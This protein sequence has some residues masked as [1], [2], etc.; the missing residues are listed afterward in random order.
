M[1]QKRILLTGAAGRIGSTFFETKQETFTFRLTDLARKSLTV[2]SPHEFVSADLREPEQCDALCK[3]VDTI[4]H[5]AGI[6]DASASFDDVLVNNMIVT[7]NIFQ[8]ALKNNCHR[9]V[10]ASSAQATE[11]YPVDVQVNHTMPVRP[12]NLYGV[13][14]CFVEALASYY[15]AEENL[16]AIALRIGAF[17]FPETHKLETTRDLSAFL[18][19]RDACHLLEQCVLTENITFFI[20]HGISNNRFKRLDLSET[21]RVLNYYP[22]DDAFEMFDLP[23]DTL[24]NSLT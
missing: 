15:A 11:A 17:E 6:P 12:K 2:S 20:G 4:I 21:T 22:Q 7:Q 19:P 24:S 3:D 8:A 14:K 16:S 9:V 5:M 18:S 10:V 13:S 23:I 1:A